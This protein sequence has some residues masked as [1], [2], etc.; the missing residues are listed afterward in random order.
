MMSEDILHE[1]E[2]EAGTSGVRGA[3]PWLVGALLIALLT[4]LWLSAPPGV[5]GKAD[6]LGY[7]VCH[8]IES[9]SFVLG[10][11]ALPLCARCT[12]TFIG[13]V[14]GLVGQV[15]V[16]RRRRAAGFPPVGILAVLIG[17]TFLWAADGLNSYL[18]LVGGPHAYEPSN[19]L[20]LVTGS[21]NGLTMS[22]LI[23]PVVNVSIWQEPREVSV[24][25][26]VWDLLV[27]V[28]LEGVL[29]GVVL[30]GADWLLYPL[31]VVSGMAVL[32]LLGSVNTV[33]AVVVAG[34]EN[35]VKTWRQ[36]LLP[37]AVGLLLALLQVA[38]IDLVRYRLTGTLDGLPI[39]Q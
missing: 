16:L 12:G 6:M 32:V 15:V 25:R 36:A 10:G 37:F 11:R 30:S 21:L 39:V 14:V 19:T 26:R 5:L 20:R 2:V 29:V 28:G 1:E 34:R 24:I 18:A 4:I 7:A 23:L 13:A 27:L 33:L 8:Q 22:S 38:A 31:S 9:H 3:V 17:F 35:S